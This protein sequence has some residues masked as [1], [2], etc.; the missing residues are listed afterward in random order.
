MNVVILKKGKKNPIES[1]C[2]SNELVKHLTSASHFKCFK[3]NI[4]DFLVSEI[5]I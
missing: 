2:N 1:K 3:K 4:T 5:N